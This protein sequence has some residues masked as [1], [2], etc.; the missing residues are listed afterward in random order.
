[1]LGVAFGD[2]YC[3]ASARIG[4]FGKSLDPGAPF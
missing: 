4:R 2:L 3:P 1:M